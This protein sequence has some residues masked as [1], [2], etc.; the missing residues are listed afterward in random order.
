MALYERTFYGHFIFAATLYRSSWS[1]KKSNAFEFSALV[2]SSVADQD[3]K[4]PYVFGPPY[5][6]PVVRGTDPDSSIIKQK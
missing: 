6:D 4:V 2:V 5:P 1:L 3:P